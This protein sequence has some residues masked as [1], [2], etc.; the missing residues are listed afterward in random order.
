MIQP[1]LTNEDKKEIKDVYKKLLKPH[2][3]HK[4]VCERIA[5]IYEVHWKTI[6]KVVKRGPK[7][8]SS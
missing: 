6:E 4:E 3:T 8:S 1:K 5:E 7:P 2:P